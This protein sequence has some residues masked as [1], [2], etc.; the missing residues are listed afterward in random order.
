MI[1]GLI[2]LLFLFAPAQLK[3]D[4]LNHIPIL[5]TRGGLIGLATRPTH[6]VPQIFHRDA[7]TLGHTETQMP[8]GRYA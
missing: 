5:K 1:H 8:V 6:L 7:S 2:Q 4:D 3:N